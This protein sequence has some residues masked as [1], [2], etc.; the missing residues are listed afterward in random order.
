MSARPGGGARVAESD[1]GPRAD[2]TPAAARGF[3]AIDK[4]A[5]VRLGG[6]DG[7]A[8]GGFRRWHADWIATDGSREKR[9]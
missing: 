3:A 5:P 6:A 7:S 9:C 4:E 2:C 1:S 8:G